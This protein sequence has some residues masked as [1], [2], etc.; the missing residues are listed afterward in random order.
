MSAK[1]LFWKSIYLHIMVAICATYSC[2]ICFSSSTSTD[3][4]AP[5][6]PLEISQ[7][8]AADSRL[9]G[10]PLER[11]FF[12]LPFLSF[13]RTFPSCEGGLHDPPWGSHIWL[14]RYL[15]VCP[16]VW[17]ISI[18]IVLTGVGIMTMLSFWKVVEIQTDTLYVII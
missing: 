17:S 2:C 3:S 8:C 14:G 1:C 7:G 16:C 11:S 9:S 12:F 10:V 4:Y 5:L 13:F 18:S 6:V 15:S